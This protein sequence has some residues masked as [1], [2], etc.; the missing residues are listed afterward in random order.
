[1]AVILVIDDEQGIREFLDT[2]L[3]RKGY[4]VVLAAEGK[5]KEGTRMPYQIVFDPTNRILRAQ[6]EGRVTDDELKE[7]YRLGQAQVARIDPHAGITDFSAVTTIEFS[8][9]T[10]RELAASTPIMPDPSRPVVFVAPTPHVFGMARM[11][12]MLVAEKRPNLHVVRT[13]EEAYAVLHVQEPQ[14]EPI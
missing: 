6:F 4:D 10:I 7:V 2:F 9:Q 13:L 12:E 11:F 1:M 14:F 3:R 5:I 8:A